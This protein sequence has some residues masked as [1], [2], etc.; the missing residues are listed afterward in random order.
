MFQ[1]ELARKFIDIY[2]DAGRDWIEA[3]PALLERFRRQWGLTLG[4][5]FAYVGYAYVVR[6]ELADGTPAVLKLAPPDPEFTNEIAA[7]RLYDGRGAVCLLDADP[8]ATAVLLERLEPG[9]PLADLDDDV[10]ATDIAAG[11][12]RQLWRPLPPGHDFPT[13]ERWGQAFARVRA[14]NRGGSGAFPPE[15]FEPAER[16]YFELCASQAGP[17]LLHGDL[18]HWNILAA[19]RG[20]WLA[21]DPK[22]VAGEPAYEVGALLR[23]RTDAEPDLRALTERRIDQLADRLGLDRRRL[24]RWAFAEGVLS[25]LWTFEGHGRI[26]EE[27]LA[28][29]RALL[30]T[31]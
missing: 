12:M 22:G 2:G 20:G 17:V 27:Q 3:C 6:A 25:A 1:P 29:P 4:E 9:T 18:H 30:P 7:L 31:I 28:L 5:T 14:A 24:V 8:D 16:L 11:V 21:I 15:L 23:N 13:V 26:G 19:Q 10:R